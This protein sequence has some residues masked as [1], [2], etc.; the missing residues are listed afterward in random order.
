MF[1]DLVRAINTPFAACSR[2]P[3]PEPGLSRFRWLLDYACRYREPAFQ[4]QTKVTFSNQLPCI[5]LSRNPE[6]QTV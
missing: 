2:L 1:I 4:T 3:E 6:E 5:V